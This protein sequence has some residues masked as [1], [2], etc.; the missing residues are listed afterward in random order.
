MSRT[1]FATP[2]DVESAFY[3]AINKGDLDAL[4]RVFA[5]EEE[6]ICIHPS[7]EQYMGAAA[8]RESWQRIFANNARLRIDIRPKIQW[9][10]TLFTAHSAEE[11]LYVGEA[12]TPQAHFFVTHIFQ[13]GAL[14]WRLV[15]RHSSVLNESAVSNNEKRILH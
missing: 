10:S 13:R 14:G 7:G 2:E 3:D 1:L 8:I 4:M 9:K 11:T 12:K 6:L 5:E 15:S